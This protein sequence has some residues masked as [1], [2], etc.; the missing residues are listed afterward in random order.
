ME[1]PRRTNKLIVLN[2]DNQSYM[3]TLSRNVITIIEKKI[4]EILLSM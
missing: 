2:I 3:K 1:G 4:I